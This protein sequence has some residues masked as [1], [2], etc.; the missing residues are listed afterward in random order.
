MT[1]SSAPTG[2]LTLSQIP[3]SLLALVRLLARE[4]ALADFATRCTSEIGRAANA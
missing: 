1:S 4:V 3:D 2:T